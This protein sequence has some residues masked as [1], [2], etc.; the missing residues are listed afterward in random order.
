MG[1]AVTSGSGDTPSTW[2]GTLNMMHA[3]TDHHSIRTGTVFTNK[4]L[5]HQELSVS[6]G[7]AHVKGPLMTAGTSTAIANHDRTVV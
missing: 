5:K 7:Q 1:S 4:A 6:L 3:V 2:E